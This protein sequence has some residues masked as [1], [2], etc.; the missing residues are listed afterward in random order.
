M[1]QRSVFVALALVLASMLL[2]A[3]GLDAQSWSGRG[4]LQGEVTDEAGKAIQGAKVILRAENGEG[5]AALVTDKKGRWSYLGLAGG[6]WTM[7]VEAEGFVPTEGA[8]RVNEFGTAPTLEVKLRKAEPV[9]TGPGDEVMAAV[10]RGNQLL[11]GGQFAAARAEYEKALALLEPAQRGPL[12]RGIARTYF[13]EGNKAQAIATLEQVLAT[14]P[15]EVET[16]RLLINLLVAEGRE[17]EA[18]GYMARLPAG[19]SVDADTL[20]NLG[21]SHYNGGK[22]EE[23]L[24]EFSRVVGEHPELPDAY[25]YRGLAHLGLGHAAEAKADFE[26]VLSLAPEHPNAGDCREFL[27]SL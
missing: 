15:D 27:K 4:R 18:R 7:R 21:I 26:K 12:L 8:V 22:L 19:S 23:A 3:S 13:Q 24:A 25:Y 16:L 9:A 1:R 6:S 10:D 14:T 5:P 11:D 2:P 17:E 20:L